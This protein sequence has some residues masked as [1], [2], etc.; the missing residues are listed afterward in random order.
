MISARPASAPDA[1]LTAAWAIGRLDGAISS[2][3][4]ASLWRERAAVIG[5]ADCLALTGVTVTP[6]EFFRL[7]TGLLP[8]AHDLSVDRAALAGAA[9]A[10]LAL[11]GD[12]PTTRHLLDVA[13]KRQGLDA[14][15]SWPIGHVEQ[16]A[17]VATLG[18]TGADV[19][20]LLSQLG[21]R[22]QAALD[23]A[24][25]PNW[26]PPVL[27]LVAAAMPGLLAAEGVT[28]TPLPCLTGLQRGPALYAGSPTALTDALLARLATQATA[29]LA[30]LHRLEACAAAWRQRLHGRTTRSR[31]GA[32]AALFLVWPALT[33]GQVARALSST[34][35]G[36]GAIL[37][38]L[39]ACD[40]LEVQRIGASRYY[41][42]PESMAD[43]K[44]QARQGRFRAPPALPARL[45]PFTD[46][47][48]AA[49]AALARFDLGDEDPTIAAGDDHWAYRDQPSGAS[50]T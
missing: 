8:A 15:L 43:F 1:A 34:P 22:V 11:L 17:V 37:D 46:D 50:V 48:D 27:A 36:A 24:E 2:S 4:I 32:A 7:L 45:A 31:T 21:H 29:G 38:M 28:A 16:A 14:G 35:P 18:R 6:A 20:T 40:I 3:S 5:L 19:G 44:I 23:A 26:A 47:V 39:I 33:R 25:Q 10:L 13:L 42:A 12:A 9:R 41:V 30:L 49:L